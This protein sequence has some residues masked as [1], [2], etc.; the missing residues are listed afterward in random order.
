MSDNAR[1]RSGRPF[2][3]E[4]AKKAAQASAEAR[5][6]KRAARE[7][8]AEANA[9]TFRQRLGVSLSRLTQE[10]LDEVVA[11]LA[12]R[13]NAA[14]LARLADQAFGRPTEAEADQPTDPGLEGL[15]R[16]QRGVLLSALEG[17]DP[18]QEL[19]EEA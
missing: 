9:L 13:G 8:T 6:A 7:Q 17:F 10:E 2:D 5:R 3:S 4:S 12:H 19:S 18:A 14:A 1:P 15:T 16:E 11:G